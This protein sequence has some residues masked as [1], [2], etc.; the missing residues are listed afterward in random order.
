MPETEAGSRLSTKGRY[1]SKLCSMC[2]LGGEQSK[3]MASAQH[4]LVLG[5]TFLDGH[6]SF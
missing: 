3:E 5:V 4:V 1:D 2:V 6:M